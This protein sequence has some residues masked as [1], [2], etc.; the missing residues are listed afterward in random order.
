MLWILNLNKIY[1]Y[2]K[3][4]GPNLEDIYHDQLGFLTVTKQTPSMFF[5]HS[6]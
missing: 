4:E 2:V 1:R 3:E 5:N 6:L